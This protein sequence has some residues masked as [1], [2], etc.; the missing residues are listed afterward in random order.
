M[1]RTAILCG[2]A[3][4]GLTV[5]GIPAEAYAAAKKASVKVVNKSDWEIHNFFLSSSEEDEW[6][7]DQLGE[8]VVGTGESFTLKSIPCDTYDVKLI[9]EDGDECVVSE[10]DVCGGQEGWIITNDDLLECQAETEDE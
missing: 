2:V 7:P 3:M 4:L 8:D 6:G 9:D 1:K 10:V 5:F